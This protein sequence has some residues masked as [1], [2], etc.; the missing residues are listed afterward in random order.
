VRVLRGV[1]ATCAVGLQRAAV[2]T[3]QTIE[4]CVRTSF[5][6]AVRLQLTES[7][8]LHTTTAPQLAG[9]IADI[10]VVAH[11][12][13]FQSAY[14]MKLAYYA[15]LISSMERKDYS[16]VCNTNENNPCK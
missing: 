16:D 7:R 11:S 1:D 15:K 4:L 12:Q 6:L 5:V 8:Q 14:C 9:V 3:D 13:M 10:A 2:A